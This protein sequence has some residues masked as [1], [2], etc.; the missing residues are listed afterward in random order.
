MEQ[1]DLI[2]KDSEGKL[3]RE[4]Q[5][6][7][8]VEEAVKV[9]LG[10]IEKKIEKDRTSILTIFGIFASIIAFLS[11]QVQILQKATSFTQLISLSLILIAGLLCFVV[12]LQWI[13]HVWIEGGKKSSLI[14]LV[15][16]IVI[17]LLGCFY[18]GYRSLS[19]TAS[20]NIL[21]GSVSSSIQVRP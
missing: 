19:D 6:T 15:I 7:L 9:R 13:T 4:D 11:V 12:A 16:I 20:Y 21:Q 18:F 5:L 10:E 1:N 3:I 8:I 2:K 14:A 17:L